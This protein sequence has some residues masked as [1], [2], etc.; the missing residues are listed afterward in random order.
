MNVKELIERECFIRSCNYYIFI[1]KF[2]D[3]NSC[4]C[5]FN[6]FSVVFL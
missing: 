4:L 1:Y 2:M 3:N 6:D 5:N